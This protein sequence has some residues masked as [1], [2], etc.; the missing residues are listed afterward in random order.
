MGVTVI[1]NGVAEVRVGPCENV[2]LEGVFSCGVSRNFGNSVQRDN[3]ISDKANFI[4]E[5]KYSINIII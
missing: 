3:I 1:H 4:P 5:E 2:T